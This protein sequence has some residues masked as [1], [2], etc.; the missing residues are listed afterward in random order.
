MF[1]VLLFLLPIGNYVVPHWLSGF[2]LLLALLALAGPRF[3]W[4]RLNSLDKAIFLTFITYFLTFILSGLINEAWESLVK[5]LG[6]ELRYLFI[7]PI[8]QVARNLTDGG[9]WLY[10]GCVVGGMVFAGNAIFESLILGRSLVAG[11]YHHILYGSTAALFAV[12]L[13]SRWWS[14]RE[15]GGWHWFSLLGA[16]ASA[17]AVALSGSRTAYAVLVIAILVWGYLE[18]GTKRFLWVVGV[19]TMLAIAIYGLSDRVAGR[20]D[21]AIDEVTY[22]FKLEDPAVVQEAL[23]SAALRLEMWRTSL[24]IIRDHPWFGVGRGGYPAAA[25]EQV[26]LGKVHWQ[27]PA[28]GQPHNAFLEAFVSLGIVGF[29]PFFGMFLLPLMRVW[30]GARRNYHSAIAVVLLL[31]CYAVTSLAAGAPFLRGSAVG[32]FIV[33]LAVLLADYESGAD[34]ERESVDA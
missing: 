21:R 18:F 22:Y 1:R 15:V 24:L 27:A 14:Q 30:Y 2:F 11:A 28:Q 3:S 29:L 12:L 17:L 23:P 19:V 26:R 34:T 7:V 32:L 4:E 5:R 31:A 25:S 6:V 13:W 8:Y 33:F 16:F 9:R 20:V 10:R